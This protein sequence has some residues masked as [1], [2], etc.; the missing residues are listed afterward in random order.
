MRPVEGLKTVRKKPLDTVQKRP[1]TRPVVRKR[2]P[3]G[4][5]PLTPRRVAFVAAYLFATFPD[6]AAAR[7]WLE[8]IRWDEDRWCPRCFSRRTT[9]VPQATPMPYRCKDCRQYFSVRTGTVM[10][11]SR[12]PLRTWVVGLGLMATHPQGVSSRQLHRALDIAQSNAWS[13]GRRIRTAWQAFIEL[14][15]R[16]EAGTDEAPRVPA[17]PAN[18]DAL[19]QALFWLHD[20]KRFEQE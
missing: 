11:S 20:Q 2:P 15:G 4:P 19:A 17:L 3:T 13:L 10:Q 9:A 6:E 18:P 5:P 16:P 7:A 14:F 1:R 8:Q 12:L